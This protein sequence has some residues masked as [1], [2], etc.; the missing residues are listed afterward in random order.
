MPGRESG[1]QCFLVES[2]QDIELFCVKPTVS[3]MWPWRPYPDPA[4][5]SPENPEKSENNP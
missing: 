4:H 5:I 2:L 3:V 1:S